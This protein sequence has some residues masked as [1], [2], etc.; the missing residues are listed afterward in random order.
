IQGSASEATLV[1]LLAARTKAVRRLQAASPG[2]TQGAIMEKLV[3]YTSDQ[4]HSSV[5]RAG[6]I[7]GVKLKA[8]PSDGKFA[9]RA[10]AL[11]EVLERDKAEGL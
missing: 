7:G 11:Q 10:S 6:L 4:A 8:I 5:E 2:L 9:M 3:A 1:A